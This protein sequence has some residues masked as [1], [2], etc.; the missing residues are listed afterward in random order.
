VNHSQQTTTALRNECLRIDE[1]ALAV[2]SRRL[3]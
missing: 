3:S 2:Q 1:S